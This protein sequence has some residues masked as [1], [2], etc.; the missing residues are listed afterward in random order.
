MY[1]VHRVVE[2]R[3]G[4]RDEEAIHPVDPLGAVF[5]VAGDL[6]AEQ[7]Q[8]VL[9]FQPEGIGKGGDDDRL[10]EAFDELVA[11]QGNAVLVEDLAADKVVDLGLEAVAGDHQIGGAAADVHAGDADFLARLA[12]LGSARRTGGPARRP[13]GE[14]RPRRGGARRARPSAAPAPPARAAWAGRGPGAWRRTT[15]AG[16]APT[17]AARSR[18]RPDGPRWLRRSRRSAR[19]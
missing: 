11:G 18:C 3:L 8:H 5:A 15:V 9:F 19:A 2:V 7:E 4:Q 6:R 12:E 16:P 10:Q 1:V 14:A 13:A 17:S